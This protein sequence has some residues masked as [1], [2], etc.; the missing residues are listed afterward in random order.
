MYPFA[1]EFTASDKENHQITVP[2]NVYF[3][4]EFS[5]VSSHVHFKIKVT[6]KSQQDI[7]Y[8]HV[9]TCKSSLNKYH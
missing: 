6:L 5:P 7:P 2:K 4:V 1:I 8:I 3:R 9:Y